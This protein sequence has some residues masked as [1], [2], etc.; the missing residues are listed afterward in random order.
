MK[1]LVDQAGMAGLRVNLIN[2]RDNIRSVTSTDGLD[3]QDSVIDANK[4]GDVLQPYP[5]VSS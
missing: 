2:V 1:Q 4:I 3:S 5:H